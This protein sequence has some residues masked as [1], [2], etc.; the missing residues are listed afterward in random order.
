MANLAERAARLN[1]GRARRGAARAA[2]FALVTDRTRVPEP[3]A[4]LASMPPGA[5]VVVRDYGAPDRAAL[6]RNL[7]RACRARRLVLV[8]AGDLDLAVAIGAGLHLPEWQAR[9]PGA[10][11]L[12]WHRRSRRV[13]SMAAHSRAAL[14]RAAGQ[15]ADLALL[16][17]VFATASHPG[18]PSLGALQFR[19][20][21]RGSRAAVWAI[22]G[23]DRRTVGLLAGSGAAGVATVGG[24]RRGRAARQRRAQKKR[25]AEAA[26][27][28]NQSQ[29]DQ[30][31]TV[32]PNRP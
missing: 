31:D 13:L 17:P 21:A 8:V 9:A 27:S 18:A 32:V 11:I 25:A 6:A 12:L 20:L 15:G 19:F 4:L 28:P 30:N 23:I 1:R 7:A 3:L 2:S 14:A 22:G 24:L 29:R 16:G 10:R 5:L 26:L